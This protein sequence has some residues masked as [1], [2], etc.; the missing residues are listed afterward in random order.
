MPSPPSLSLRS[1]DRSLV[2]VDDGD[3]AHQRGPENLAP[4]ARSGSRTSPAASIV[5]ASDRQ[6]GRRSMRSAAATGSGW[7]T[8][9]SRSTRSGSTLVVDANQHDHS[10]SWFTGPA[11]TSSKP[12]ST[13]KFRAGSISTCMCSARRSRSTGVEGSHSIHGFSSRVQLDDVAGSVR[14]HTFSGSVEIR[15]KTVGRRSVDRRRHV[16]RHSA[17]RSG[18]RARVRHLQLVQ[19]PSELGNAPHAAQQQPANAQGRARRRPRAAP[20]GSRPSAAASGSTG[21]PLLQ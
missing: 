16:Q 18:K 10:S 20:C 6:R 9:S 21:N 15:A 2:A 14:A 5:T 17:A 7:T 3:R 19:R 1:S 12:T 13:S 8:S 4:G 11:T